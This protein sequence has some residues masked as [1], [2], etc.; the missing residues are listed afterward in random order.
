MQCASNGKPKAERHGRSGRPAPSVQPIQ[1]APNA[2]VPAS[3]FTIGKIFFKPKLKPPDPVKI[4]QYSQ[5]PVLLQ[6]GTFDF[7]RA[8]L[9]HRLCQILLLPEE[10]HYGNVLRHSEGPRRGIPFDW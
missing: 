6:T 1:G 9:F 2:Q 7:A 3:R 8:E 4:S 5:L 10:D